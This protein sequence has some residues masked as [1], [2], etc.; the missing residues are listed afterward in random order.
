MIVKMKKITLLVSERAR[1]DML[2]KLR[3]L[4]VV[5]I[6]NLTAPKGEDIRGVEDRIS[7]VTRALAILSTQALDKEAVSMHLDNP[8]EIEAVTDETLS[9]S[10]EREGLSKTLDGL[11]ASI[12]WYRPWGA[13]DPS[14]IE[15]LKGKGIH[16]RL[17]RIQSSQIKKMRD[18]KDIHIISKD[19]TYAYIALVSDD[20]KLQLPFDEMK[21]TKE[22]FD[23]AHSE[24]DRSEKRIGE[25]DILLKEKAPYAD[26]LKSYISRLDIKRNFL[27]VKNG[28]KKEARFSC[29]QGFAP[30]DTLGKITAFSS[31]EGLGYLIEDP[32]PDDDVP[33]LVRNPK[34]IRIIN[35]VF[36]FMNTVP[37]YKELDISPWFL[38]FLSLFFAMLIGD[39]GYGVLFMAA[40]FFAQRKF[41]GAPPEPFRLIY[42]FASATIVWGAVTGTWFGAERIARFPFFSSMVI[43]SI[44]SF[45]VGNQN[46]MI[47]ICFVIGVVHLTLAHLLLAFDKINTLKAIAEIGWIAILWGLFFVAGTLVIGNPF[48]DI[49][50]KLLIAGTIL[51]LLFS[52]P[53]RNI[54]KG[55][56]ASLADLPIKIIGSFS[57]VV[58]YLRLFAVGYASVVL[59]STFN[60]M[61]LQLGFGNFISGLAAA[62][63]LFFGHTLN[64]ILGLMAVIVHGIRL[65]MLEF[66]GQM[67]MEWSGKEYSPFRETA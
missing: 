25:I 60:D 22:S 16:V 57:D 34:W 56:F 30:V 8:H 28:M 26:A 15:A 2:K 65:N 38:G 54:L 47:Y 50:V 35:P 5:H 14:E 43:D 64:I 20:E 42:L 45:V 6:K 3:S 12:H 9:L 31:Q 19:K 32:S 46:F 4:G 11:R 7:S 10:S 13:F 52:N 44:D 23:R 21:L 39:A 36:K 48:N 37:G 58:S 40:A 17:Y 53:R 1:E 33:T 55:I 51:V 29:V 62:L 41:K 49:A 59:A 61:A 66:S 63:I 67:G 27:G 24:H 18:R